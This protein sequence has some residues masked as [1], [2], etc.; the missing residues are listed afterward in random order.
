MD[1]GMN[2][3]PEGAGSDGGSSSTVVA[4]KP[5]PTWPADE[6]C[7]GDQLPIVGT[8]DGYIENLVWPSGS[9]A[10]RVVIR[11]ANASHVCGTV[12]FGQ[13]TPPPPPTDPEVGYPPGYEQGGPTP[14]LQ[15]ALFEGFPMALLEGKATEFRLQFG[16]TSRELWKS[17]CELQ[18]SYVTSTGL[19]NCLPEPSEETFSPPSGCSEVTRDGTYLPLDCGKLALCLTLYPVCTCSIDGCTVPPYPEVR[20]DMRITGGA[21]QG[22]VA[23]GQLHNLY[24]DR[25]E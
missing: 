21:A 23:F 3:P 25:A 18:T 14:T 24:L 6:Q 15:D 9:D 12:T 4:P 11:A 17:W 13:G 2:L 7:Q 19:Y 10:L 20:F 8:W 16:A 22:S 5:V 1:L